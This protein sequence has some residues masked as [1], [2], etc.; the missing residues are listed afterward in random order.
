MIFIAIKYN[1]SE[2]IPKV[3]CYRKLRFAFYN[4]FEYINQEKNMPS[5]S[6]IH[7]ILAQII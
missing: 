7:M 5:S 2:I 1:I 4:Y 3:R 6:F